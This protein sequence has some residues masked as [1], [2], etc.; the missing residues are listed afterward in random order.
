MKK[1]LVLLAF[2]IMGCPDETGKVDPYLTARNIINQK[3]LPIAV[4][5]SIFGM[6]CSK[7]TDQ[8]KL[9][10]T[11]EKYQKIKAAV[12]NGLQVAL[13]GVNIAEQAQK[14]P[15]LTDLM[16]RAN[17]AWTS[18]RTFLEELLGEPKGTASISPDEASQPAT[19]ST[20]PI[21]M[22]ASALKASSPLD[23]L[24]KRLY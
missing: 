7:Q 16:D 21:A 6:W 18:L 17:D 1:T 5:D 4:A 19:D 9:K 13:E 14:D 2:L 15:N 20:D 10:A 8:E 3:H 24:P 23:K 22:K 12:L 11:Q